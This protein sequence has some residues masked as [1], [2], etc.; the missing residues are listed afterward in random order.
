MNNARPA[1]VYSHI[2]NTH[3]SAVLYIHTHTY[4]NTHIDMN[5]YM[6]TY[7][8]TSEMEWIFIKRHSEECCT[9]IHR[10]HRLWW[11]PINLEQSFK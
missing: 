2:H 10:P 11:L 8:P 1:R 4:I 6:H 5:A 7:L 9:M 3:T